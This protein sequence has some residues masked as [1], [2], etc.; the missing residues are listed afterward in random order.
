MAQSAERGKGEEWYLEERCNQRCSQ[1][2]V[3]RSI[4]SDLE[5]SDDGPYQGQGDHVEDMSLRTNEV[6]FLCHYGGSFGDIGESEKA[7]QDSGRSS[8]PL[9]VILAPFNSTEIN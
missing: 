4:L 6:I 3:P 7:N 8:V 2:F 1:E 5:S 9:G